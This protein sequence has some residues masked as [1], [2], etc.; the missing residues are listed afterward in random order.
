MKRFFRFVMAAAVIFSA[1]SCAKED[2]SS[3]IGGGEVE[4]TFTADLGQLGTRAYGEADNVDV[5]YLGVYEA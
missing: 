5:V 4:V 2:I 1:V 3:T